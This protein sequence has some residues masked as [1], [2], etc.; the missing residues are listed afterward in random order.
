MQKEEERKVRIKLEELKEEIKRFLEKYV[1]LGIRFFGL[2][3]E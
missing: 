1:E 3:K 2:E